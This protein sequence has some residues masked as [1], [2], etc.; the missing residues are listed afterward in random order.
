[1]E[2]F[3]DLTQ[4]QVIPDKNTNKKS[5][6]WKDNRHQKKMENLTPCRIET[7]EQIDT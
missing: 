6:T 7:L 1:M 2:N 5:I 3:C 4:H